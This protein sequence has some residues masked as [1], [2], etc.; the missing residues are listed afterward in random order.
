MAVL[1]KKFGNNN[2][3][4]MIVTNAWWNSFNQMFDL[5]NQKIRVRLILL[6]LVII[7]KR[8]IIINK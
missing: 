6:H 8:L 5:Y 2:Q 1:K 7:I 3:V 4:Q